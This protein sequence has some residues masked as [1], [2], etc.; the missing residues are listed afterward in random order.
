MP[1]RVVIFFSI[2]GMAEE[3]YVAFDKVLKRDIKRYIKQ[4]RHIENGANLRSFV[5]D[6]VDRSLIEITLDETNGNQ[7]QTAKILGVSRNTLNRKMKSFN[8]N[9]TPQKESLT[10]GKTAKSGKKV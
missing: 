4:L 5:V 7:S 6:L 9:Q 1:R 2:G 3:I 8:L 10:R